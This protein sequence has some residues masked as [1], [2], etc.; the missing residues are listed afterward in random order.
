[1]RVN[2]HARIPCEA[3]VEVRKHGIPFGF[4]Q[5]GLRLRNHFVVKWLLRP[6]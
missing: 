3:G 1:V 5:G 2:Q 4:A 6:G